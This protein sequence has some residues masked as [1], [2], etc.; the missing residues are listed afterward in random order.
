MNNNK[1]TKYI[2]ERLLWWHICGNKTTESVALLKNNMDKI[3]WNRLSGNPAAISIIEQCP[4]EA[5]QWS[6]FHNP[7][8]M[9]LIEKYIKNN[10]IHDRTAWYELCY[11]PAAIP[12]LEDYIG[13]GLLNWGR[14]SNNCGA[15]SMLQKNVANICWNNIGANPSAI[16]LIEER[17][18]QIDHYE[19]EYNDDDAIIDWDHVSLNPSA[20]SLI[21][22]N[23]PHI[24]WRNVR[25][26]NPG[27]AVSLDT[28][29]K[30]ILNHQPLAY[31]SVGDSDRHTLP[32]KVDLIILH[33]ELNR[34][35]FSPSNIRN[36][37]YYD[38]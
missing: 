8:A 35:V 33:K 27:V 6:L 7:A 20:M 19:D 14:L 2:H 13:T 26:N 17:A 10:I 1:M 23:K 12:F 34:V 31:P 24:D 32:N 11:N 38:Q 21:E 22:H 16:R 15:L 29:D 5:D 28:S 4:G 36:F 30:Y 18:C 37:S 3:I 25:L 9:H